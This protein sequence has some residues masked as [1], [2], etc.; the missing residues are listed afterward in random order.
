MESNIGNALLLLLIGMSTVY[1]MLFLLVSFGKILIRW[2][3]KIDLEI[4]ELPFTK[5]K[6]ETSLNRHE[7]AIHLA[8]QKLSDNK[9]KVISI[10]K[11]K[12]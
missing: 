7:A 12:S 9:A 3:N 4:H 2:V 10:E 1:L 11:L 5:L 8:I 6:T